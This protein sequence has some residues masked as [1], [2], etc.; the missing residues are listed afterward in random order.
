MERSCE[1]IKSLFFM[2][3]NLDRRVTQNFER[4]TGISL[5]RFEMLYT[6]LNKGELSQI[7]LQQFLKIDQAAITRHLKILEEKGYVIRSRNQQNNR[8]VIVRITDTG[9]QELEQCDLNRKQ[10]FDELFHEFT[11]QDISQLQTLVRKLMDNTEK[12]SK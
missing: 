9:K 12:Q 6:L 5:T 11:D 1:E 3:Q 8:E 4:R 7:V 10:F 2:L